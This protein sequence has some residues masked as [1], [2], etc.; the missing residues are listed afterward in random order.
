MER[1]KV[2]DKNKKPLMETKNVCYFKE[3]RFS[4]MQENEERNGKK[5]QGREYV[6]DGK[7]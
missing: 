4:I 1:L 3:G 7:A 6:K 2:N 5:K